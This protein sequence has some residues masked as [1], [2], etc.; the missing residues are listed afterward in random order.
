MMRELNFFLE[1][2]GTNNNE[3]NGS[4]G[5][6]RK[7]C[8]SEN[9]AENSAAL[10]I[11][12]G[13]LFARRLPVGLC[14]LRSNG[15]QGWRRPAHF[16]PPCRDSWWDGECGASER[17]TLFTCAALSTMQVLSFPSLI[18]IDT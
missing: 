5:V 17:E 15:I 2:G 16:H 7:R 18:I 11:S 13:K 4:S 14:A 9:S 12:T 1:K 8:K 10:I 3:L 6:E